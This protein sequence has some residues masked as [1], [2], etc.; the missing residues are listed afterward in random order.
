VV[1]VVLLFELKFML[2]REVVAKVVEVT[3][4]PNPFWSSKLVPS[5]NE[6][7]LVVRSLYIVSGSVANVSVVRR[8]YEPSVT[9]AT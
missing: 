3:D 6:T 2:L 9:V 5:S 1:L 4:S 8:L 7:E